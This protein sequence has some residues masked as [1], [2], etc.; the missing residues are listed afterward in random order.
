[1]A[2]ELLSHFRK[3][4]SHLKL[5]PSGGGAFEVSADG[6]LVFSKLQEGRFPEPKELKQAIEQL[7]TAV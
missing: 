5:V 4:I 7:F 3:N 2:L 6:R 1:M